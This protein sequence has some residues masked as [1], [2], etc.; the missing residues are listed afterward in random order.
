MHPFNA[1]PYGVCDGDHGSSTTVS[2]TC[3]HDG[4]HDAS[5]RYG[6]F[7]M[8]SQPDNLLEHQLDKPPRLNYLSAHWSRP[9]C[10]EW[11]YRSTSWNV[12]SAGV[13]RSHLANWPA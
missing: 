3:G 1:Y 4:H 6:D 10:L 11:S 7:F 5:L 2:T 12:W 13:G 8:R 9:S